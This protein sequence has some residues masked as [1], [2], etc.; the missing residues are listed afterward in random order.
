MIHYWTFIS[1]Y[2]T[3]LLSG[4]YG[5]VG[6]FI[7]IGGNP[8]LQKMSDKTFAEYWQHI[9]YYMAARMKIFGPVMLVSFII[10][11]IGL[12]PVYHTPSFWLM[13][14]A[15]VIIISDVVFTVR[16]NHPLNRLIQSWD[17]NKLPRDVGQIKWR[18]MHAFSY[19]QVFMISSFVLVVL[20]VWLIKKP[21]L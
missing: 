4:L 7:A 12:L 19:R 14:I 15:L 21:L 17:I 1:L 16:V 5:G 11:T 2:I 3:T 18:V 9:D 20:A 10:T 8:S 6:F 13:A